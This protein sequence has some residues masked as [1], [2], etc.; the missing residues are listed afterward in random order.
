MN[1]RQVGFQKLFISNHVKK[2]IMIVYLI[3]EGN[4]GFHDQ[5]EQFGVFSRLLVVCVFESGRYRCK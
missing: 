5:F 4:L 2:F 3:K 1:K